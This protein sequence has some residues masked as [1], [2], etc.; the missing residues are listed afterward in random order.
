[1]SIVDSACGFAAMTLMPAESLVL[2]VDLSINLLLPAREG[3][4]AHG[5]VVRSG[6]TLT[7]CQAT[8]VRRDAGAR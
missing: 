5:E 6:G 7:V 4:G 3:L 1:M 2:T 8:M